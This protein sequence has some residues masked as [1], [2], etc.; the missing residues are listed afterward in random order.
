MASASPDTDVSAILT[1]GMQLYHWWYWCQCFQMTK[2]LMLYL[3]LVSW[4]KE[5]NGAIDNDISITWHQYQ[6]QRL[7]MNKKVMLHLISIVPTSGMQWC[8]WWCQQHHV[9]LTPVP[10]ASQYQVA[11]HFNPL[12]IRNAVVPFL[13]T[14]VTVA[15]HKQKI[16]LHLILII[17]TNAVVSLIILVAS[18]DTDISI[19]GIMWCKSSV[20]HCFRPLDLMNAMVLLIIPLAAHDADAS[21]N[22]V[23]L[24][25]RACYMVIF[26]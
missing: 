23:K 12:D 7:H 16:I 14:L 22:S 19:N 1:Y 20:T 9:T 10:I 8:H 3:I 5:C 2:K 25:K 4:P 11:P 24:L 21:A 26:N 15:S 17:L 6:C 18:C 13:T